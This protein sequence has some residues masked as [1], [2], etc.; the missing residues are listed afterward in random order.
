MNTIASIAE[1]DRER[2]EEAIGYRFKDVALLEQALTHSSYANEFG[3]GTEHN[4]RLEFLGDAVMELCVSTVLYRRFPHAREGDLTLLRSSLV[5]TQSFA[6]FARLTGID[7]CLFLGRGEDAQGGR[8]RD[9]VLSDAFE[10][11]VAAVYEDGGFDAARRVVDKVFEGHWPEHAS[12]SRKDRDHKTSLQEICHRLF[13]GER[14]IYAQIAAEG[15]SH[16]RVFTVEVA[17]PDGRTF[18][19]EGT[20]CKRAEQN[21]AAAALAVLAD[22]SSAAP[23]AAAAPAAKP[24]RAGNRKG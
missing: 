11:V 24:A 5:S 9:T 10:A 7:R 18:R 20:S 14:P 4:E 1:G 6:R 21:A 22:P 8:E 19:A 13:A 12:E 16:A 15:P 23:S 17:L 2:L 3:F